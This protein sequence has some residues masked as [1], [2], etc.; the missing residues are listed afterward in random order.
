MSQRTARRTL[1][2]FLHA[3]RPQRAKSRST[4][5]GSG[6]SLHLVGAVALMLGLLMQ[7]TQYSNALAS[8]QTQDLNAVAAQ[9]D[10]DVAPAPQQVVVVGDFQD[11]L[12]CNNSDMNCGT[13]QLTNQGGIWVGSFPIQPGNYSYQIGTVGADGQVYAFGQGGLN[14]GADSISINDG[15]VGAYFSFNA[16]T[17]EIEAQALDAIG[18]LNTDAGAFPLDADLSTIIFTNNGGS[19]NFQVTINGEVVGEPGSLDLQPGPNRISVGSDGSLQDVESLGYATLAVSRTVDGQA[20]AGSCYQVRDGNDVVAQGC[21][22]DDGSADGNTF[23]TFAAGADSGNYELHEAVAPDGADAAEDQDVQID[24]GDNSVQVES[25]Q[26]GEVEPRTDGGDD[27]G[28]DGG[29]EETP[30][31][32]GSDDDGGDDGQ[33]GP[34]DET[35]TEEVVESGPGDLIVSLT[36]QEGNPIGEA[37]FQLIDQQ[38]NGVAESCD[39]ADFG[40]S[41]PGNGNTGFFGV[42]AGTYVLHQS[43]APEGTEPVE[44]QNVDIVADESVNVQVTAEVIEQEPTEEPTEEATAE[45]TEEEAQ[46]GDIVVVREDQDGNSIAG[47]CFVAFDA[48]GNQATDEICDDDGDGRI[49]FP[50][51]AAGTAFLRETRTPDGVEQAEDMQIEVAA[52]ESTEIDVTT[53]GI[54]TEEPTE[55]P[56]EEATAE[57]TEEEAQTG[58]IVVLRQD[59]DGNAVGGACFVAFDAN[60]NQATDEVCDEDGDVADDGRIGFTGLAAGTAFLRETRT[61]D[62]VEPAEDMQIEVVAGEATDIEVRTDRIESEEPTAEPTEE[63]ATAEPTEEE[64]TAEPTEEEATAEP[65]E[66]EGQDGQPADGPPGDLI[67][68]LLDENDE[69]IG[70]ACFELLNPD[71]SVAFESCD[72]PEFGDTNPNNGNTGFYGVPSGDYILHQSL[73]PEGSEA[74]EDSPVTVEEGTSTNEIVNATLTGDD[75]GEEEPTEEATEEA[76]PTEETGEPGGVFRVDVTAFNEFGGG[77]CVQ[78]ESTGSISS[79]NPPTACDNG[80][81][82]NNGEP[83]IIDFAG[84]DSSDYRVVI[85]E[86][87]DEALSAP[88]PAITTGEDGTTTALFSLTVEPTTEPTVE[89]TAEPTEE[90]TLEPTAEPTE[91]PEPE[92]G[93]LRV[94]LTDEDGN[95]IAVEG[96][97]VRVNEI[98]QVICDNAD[99]ETDPATGTMLI[100]GLPFGTY[101]VSG[102]TAPEGF[103][104]TDEVTN[105]TVESVDEEGVA[106][107]VFPAIAPETGTITITVT[108]EATGQPIAGGCFDLA[109]EF[110][111]FNFCDDDNDGTIA[112]P[113]VSLGNQT[114]T[115]TSAAE[116]YSVDPEP[117]QIELTGD[118]PDASVSFANAVANGSILVSITDGEAPISVEGTCVSVNGLDRTICDNGEGDSD[119]AVGS[120][121]IEDV[122]I[123]SYNLAVTEAPEGY[124]IPEIAAVAEV[125]STTEPT[126]VNLPLTLAGPTTGTI[127]IN[128]VDDTSEAAIP[129]GCFDV[130]N[131]TG[132]FNFCDDDSDGT[133]TVPEVSFGNQ[134]ITQTAAVEG[135]EIDPSPQQ[136]NL[137]QDAPEATVTFRN[138]AVPTAVTVQ[139][140]T[141]DGQGGVPTGA[142]YTIDGGEPICDEDGDGIV[143]FE[144]VAPGSH[145]FEQSTPPE[146]F[147]PVDGQDIEIIPGE[148]ESV[149]FTNNQAVNGSLVVSILDPDGNLV[150]NINVTIAE[151]VTVTDNAADDTDPDPGQVGFNDLVAG[152]YSVTLSGVPADFV[153]PEATPVTVN[154]GEQATLEIP[155]TAAEAQ[156]GSVEISLEDEEGND[157]EGGCVTLTKSAEGEVLGPFCDNDENDS[158]PEESTLLLEDIETGTWLVSSPDE[159]EAN[160]FA[161]ATG[162]TTRTIEVQAN[163]IVVVVIIIIGVPIDGALQI[164]TRDDVTNAII[165]GACYELQDGGSSLD[166]CDNDATDA[167]GTPGIIRVNHFDPGSY[168]ITLTNSIPGYTQDDVPTADVEVG[169]LTYITVDLVPTDEFGSVVVNKVDQNGNELGNS[170]FALRQNG[171]IIF[172]QCDSNDADVNDGQLIFENVPPGIYRLIETKAPSSEYLI[173][174]NL[175][176]TVV[177]GETEEYTRTNT[178]KPADLIVR[179]V[180]AGDGS[181][182]LPGACFSLEDE[183][184]DVVF[185]SYCDSSD[186]TNDGR[187]RFNDVPV[188][189]YTI[190]EDVAP[191]GYAKAGPLD[192]EI[193]PGGN[194]QVVN[195]A[196]EKLPPPTDTGSLLIYKQDGGKKI[197]VGACFRLYDGNNPL[198]NTVCDGTDGSN[199]GIIRFSDIPVGTWELRETIA[200]SDAYQ[201][202]APSDVE[203]EKDETT[204]VTVVNTLKTGRIKV[205]K[206]NPSGT[207][208]QGACFDVLEDSAGEKCTDANGFVLFDKLAPG[209]YT[210]RETKA[211]Y[212]YQAIKDKTGIKVY[213]AKTTITEIVDQRIP[214]DPNTGSVQVLKFYCPAGEAGERTVFLG[215]AAGNAELAKTAGCEVGNA[216]FNLDQDDGNGGPG[217]FTVGNDGRYQVSVPAGTYTL[218]ETDPDLEGNSSVKLKVYKNQLTTVVV[219][220]YL[221]PPEPDPITIN[222]TKWTCTPSF[223]GTLYDDFAQNCTEDS[224]LTNNITFR[225][226]GPTNQK[227]VSGDGG[228]LG[229]TTFTDLTPGNYSLY[230]ELPYNI[231]TSYGYCGVDSSW[232]A[233]YKVVNGAFNLKLDWG[234]TLTCNF[235]NIPEDVTDTTGVVLVR[236]FVCDIKAPPKG[237]DWFEECSLSDQNAKFALNS[238]NGKTGKFQEFTQGTANNDGFL[239]FTKLKPG[240][241]ELKEIGATWCHAESDNVDSKGNVVVKA[242][243]VS[244]VWI[245]NCVPTKNPPNTGS[246]D[247]APNPPPVDGDGNNGGGLAPTVTPAISYG[248][249]LLLAAAWITWKRSQRP[250]PA[251]IAIRTTNNQR[252]RAA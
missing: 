43:Q 125:T 225:A 224:Q 76:S 105:G 206:T 182:L 153:A 48:N 110:G 93:S 166:V 129:A 116:G 187:T 32:D 103:E 1:A 175:Q 21:D 28:G 212:G 209:S 215:G 249:P 69:P 66:D 73:A 222:V 115:Q 8:T 45:P 12:G 244:T 29:E 210:L 35:P 157:A 149:I 16:S 207:A 236:K 58:D 130:A 154:A 26:G 55:E 128:V 139:V 194:T 75:G 218:E 143:N 13:T 246:G 97:C 145:R 183:N 77:I 243:K 39:R 242:G 201:A 252:D 84:I 113:D 205:E 229:K 219:I 131:D 30:T 5:S 89:P 227:H 191:Y 40:D 134:T 22:I 228:Q 119:P 126:P 79:A 247:A 152:D 127:T 68:S 176:I 112:I 132:T 150:P 189:E 74:R 61:P 231:P 52:G 226:E 118:A 98:D 204:E 88:E 162:G 63:E 179:K 193:Q 171:V 41:N 83:G 159:G 106:T 99:P 199:D 141:S 14:G 213:A 19:L 148:V 6:R 100:V 232:P 25:S 54:A 56:T 237:Y 31:D 216:A 138:V 33:V 168:T 53:A 161:A 167:N 140:S 20:A 9:S 217:N 81:G 211:P 10:G 230:E 78:L 51:L 59:Q 62:G 202:A 144:N 7:V 85:T 170:C 86:G 178:L 101:S 235:F 146:G 164:T 241:Y 57:P 49:E 160:T 96:A 223:N 133:I 38:G 197:L 70:G 147:Q 27:D 4:M 11:Q 122:P 174:G 136:V 151:G 71:G 60:G 142:C 47:A 121:L 180:D 185:G 172:E 114:L 233:D 91:T 108:D 245:F 65:T 64:A 18:I 90:P 72:S 104:T 36:D 173:A 117:Q 37:C 42:P 195:V 238:Y 50:G 208:L 92:L 198:T 120:I 34:G 196:N 177:A 163:V 111:T 3:A 165:P 248:W 214:A 95:P 158:N 200:P 137:T 107:V 169:T 94:N 87:P 188:G 102:S 2:D 239:R 155:L 192:I 186:G 184:G 17:Y 234:D 221:A 181:T 156:T 80:E 24:N 15:Q 67:V 251:P 220:N 250:L 240:T 82:D 135:Y 123:G 46:T 44:D 190:V 124:A 23:I 109:N 203:I